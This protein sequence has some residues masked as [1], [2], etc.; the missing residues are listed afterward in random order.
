MGILSLLYKHKCMH[1]NGKEV[2]TKE[3]LHLT[4]FASTLKGHAAIKE[5]SV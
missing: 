1:L 4:C 2:F 3:R 5:I